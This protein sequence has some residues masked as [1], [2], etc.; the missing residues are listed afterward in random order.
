MF[1]GRINLYRCEAARAA[2]SLAAGSCCDCEIV[3]QV[4]SSR[5]SAAFVIATAKAESTPAARTIPGPGKTGHHNKRTQARQGVYVHKNKNTEL[6][7]LRLK[8]Y[9]HNAASMRFSSSGEIS[10]R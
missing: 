5:I 2:V 3:R 1:C 8:F 4:N 7:N 10:H 6:L 9:H